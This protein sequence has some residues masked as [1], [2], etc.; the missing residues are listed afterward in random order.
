[1]YITIRVTKAPPHSAPWWWYFPR[2]GFPC[3]SSLEE[4]LVSGARGARPSGPALL[5]FLIL[6]NRICLFWE[7]DFLCQKLLFRIYDN[8]NSLKQ[9]KHLEKETAESENETLICQSWELAFPPQW[10]E[11]FGV[12]AAE[13]TGCQ[14]KRDDNSE[15]RMDAEFL[16]PLI[17]VAAFWSGMEERKKQSST[18]IFWVHNHWSKCGRK[19]VMDRDTAGAQLGNT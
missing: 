16:K 11:D 19:T 10:Q 17:N 2:G 5:D 15:E 8:W 4:S 9:D 18:V 12:Q 1:M 7:S 14:V 6:N 3:R 13:E